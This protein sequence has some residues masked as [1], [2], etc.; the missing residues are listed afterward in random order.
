MDKVKRYL[1]ERKHLREH[2][3]VNLLDADDD[4]TAVVR[5]VDYDHLSTHLTAL[6]GALR[7]TLDYI[8]H[9]NPSAARI[10][11]WETN[12]TEV[13]KRRVL[14][15]REFNDLLAASGQGVGKEE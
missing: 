15:V 5:V 9:K 10:T 6:E 1:V 8:K 11:W 7:E 4:V 12:D 14:N 3:P 13:N 2:T